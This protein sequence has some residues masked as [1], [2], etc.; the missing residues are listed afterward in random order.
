[1][2]KVISV[3]IFLVS[4]FFYASVS[5]KQAGEGYT[6]FRYDIPTELGNNTSLFDLDE[7]G[8]IVGTYFGGGFQHAFG[9]DQND[10]SI[11]E[12]NVEGNFI[13]FATAISDLAVVGSTE[14]PDGRRVGTI[15]PRDSS[16]KT[17][18]KILEPLL[19]SLPKQGRP[20]II[21]INPFLGT[22]LLGVNN[23]GH[24]V[25][26]VQ[27]LD[28]TSRGFVIAKGQISVF[29]Y[30]GA[31]STEAEGIRKNGTIVG[32][33]V[34]NGRRHGFLL[35]PSGKKFASFDVDVGGN[36]KACET[37]IYD[38]NDAGDLAGVYCVVCGC[39]Q[40]RGYVFTRKQQL[41]S[42]TYPGVETT[43]TEVRGLDEEGNIVGLFDTET[44][45]SNNKLIKERHGFIGLLK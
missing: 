38:T 9:S 43:N 29:D 23:R 39:E 40:K 25:G 35:N 6:L 16:S 44:L 33:Y 41:I 13:N 20:I 15:W 11:T 3:V 18:K 2:N 22:S 21:D 7:G 5:A 8:T 24:L 31:Q 34:L 37:F 30:P 14:Q 42:I 19:P 10:E 1:M 27:K 12:Y 17:W 32:N 4:L 28:S 45:D 36:K 26:A